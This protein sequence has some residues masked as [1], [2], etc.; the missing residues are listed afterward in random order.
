MR[1]SIYSP[2]TLF[3]LLVRHRHHHRPTPTSTHLGAG[4]VQAM[5]GSCIQELATPSEDVIIRH[6]LILIVVVHAREVR[7]VHL[8]A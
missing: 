6:E 4:H 1:V 3:D 5:A 8:V 2:L 7:K